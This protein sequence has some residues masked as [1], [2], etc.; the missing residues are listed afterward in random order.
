MDPQK[1]GWS[2]EW[3]DLAHVWGKWRA[4]INAVLQLR[5]P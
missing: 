2:V 5:F 1:V 4:L 3:I